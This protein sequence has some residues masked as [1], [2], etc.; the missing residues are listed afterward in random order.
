MDQSV[1]DELSRVNIVEPGKE[2]NFRKKGSNAIKMTDRTFMQF[3]MNRKGGLFNHRINAYNSIRKKMEKEIEK[4]E[5]NPEEADISKYATLEE[6]LSKIGAKI[7]WAEEKE[8]F[9]QRSAKKLKVPAILI[10]TIAPF[11]NFFVRKKYKK[12][13][14]KQVELA[15]NTVL[16]DAIK[17]ENKGFN[18]P[19]G[20]DLTLS[21]LHSNKKEESKPKQESSSSQANGPLP[22]N[23]ILSQGME[24]QEEK[25]PSEMKTED[26]IKK[27]LEFYFKKIGSYS[28]EEYKN[29]LENLEKS[30]K[31]IN[32]NISDYLKMNF[33]DYVKD[34]V[35]N[36]DVKS[37]SDEDIETFARYDE[38]SNKYHIDFA[39]TREEILKEEEE[40]LLKLKEE[41]EKQVVQ[42]PGQINPSER[43]PVNNEGQTMKYQ[44]FDWSKYQ[45]KEPENVA[46]N[47][48]EE[49]KTEPVVSQENQNTDEPVYTDNSSPLSE[50]DNNHIHNSGDY[51]T[52]NSSNTTKDNNNKDNS[53]DVDVNNLYKEYNPDITYDYNYGVINDDLRNLSENELIKEEKKI[54]ESFLSY[55][56]L[57]HGKSPRELLSNIQ[58][59]VEET[60]K[61]RIEYNKELQEENARDISKKELP[62]L[63]Q[64][65]EIPQDYYLHSIYSN[66][67]FKDNPD[68][69]ERT[70]KLA[71]EVMRREEEK[72]KAKQAELAKIKEQ[73]KIRTGRLV[74]KYGLG[75]YYADPNTK[76]ND[77]EVLD[78]IDLLEKQK[79]YKDAMRRAGMKVKQ[80]K[81]ERMRQQQVNLVPQ[82]NQFVSNTTEPDYYFINNQDIPKTR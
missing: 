49:Q 53:S 82:S 52:S 23:Q 27:H 65:E 64:V 33:K 62:L 68:Q 47:I 73:E 28:E 37:P 36:V 39:K 61:Q 43:T 4:I 76:L 56:L 79:L 42:V 9:V 10:R 81:E 13:Y 74:L 45:K 26:D 7:L 66:E 15:A 5:K 8:N 18:I 3:I 19:S 77:Q 11:R 59:Y 71:N 44:H 25:A 55:V 35:L 21:T 70:Q 60:N 46:N 80:I 2:K 14:Q 38:I 50:E 22:L 29:I 67:F 16:Q 17:E 1:M 58:E 54:N 31:D 63:N 51:Q 72:E 57:K 20:E 75:G 30:A 34:F 12:L 40:R 32:F 78:M 24:K 41:Q 69:Y 6:K 48:E